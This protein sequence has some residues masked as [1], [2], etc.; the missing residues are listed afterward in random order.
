M[1]RSDIYIVDDNHQLIF[2]KEYL[3]GI[4]E[5]KTLLER[6]MTKEGDFD[7]RKKL[8]HWQVFLY[9]KIVADRFS[10]PN[11]GGYNDDEVHVA[12]IKESKL[13]STFKPDK[14]VLAAIEKFKEIQDIL[15][16]TLSTINT[17]LKGI[18]SS[19]AIAQ[20]L[21]KGI[22]DQIQL[23]KKKMEDSIRNGETVNI[24]DQI[25]I[26]DGL[27]KQLASVQKIAETVPRT[28]E[29]L[30]KLEERLKKETAGDVVGR[31]GKTIG[32]RADPKK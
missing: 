25:L 9:V 30:E 16:P 17:V 7:G 26:V 22:N 6:K 21:V 32:N 18:R 3:R 31:G 8:M 10:F 15:L 14:D 4:P 12:A 2:D 24:A 19:D 28:Q 29:T 13:D 1:R 27:L 23:Y 20:I 11:L 5:F